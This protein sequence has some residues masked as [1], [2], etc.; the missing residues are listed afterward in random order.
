MKSF[1]LLLIAFVVAVG[2]TEDKARNLEHPLVN[3]EGQ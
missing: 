1:Y 2:C 3:I